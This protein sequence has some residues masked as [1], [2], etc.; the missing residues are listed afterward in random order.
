MS[1]LALTPREAK[2]THDALERLSAL[3]ADDMRETLDWSR[4]D[5]RAWSSALAKVDRLAIHPAGRSS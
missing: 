3:T 4:S 1:R 5:I 2:V